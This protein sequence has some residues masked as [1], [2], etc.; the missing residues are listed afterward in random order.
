MRL[1]PGSSLSKKARIHGGGA[2]DQPQ[3]GGAKGG[4]RGKGKM[5]EMV[6]EERGLSSPKARRTRGIGRKLKG[7]GGEKAFRKTDKRVLMGE[8]RSGKP[9]TT[10]R[11]IYEK[12]KGFF[13]EIDQ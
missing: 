13:A 12:K 8:Q 3:G 2:A 9:T 4:G 1:T 11:F 10:R 6:G 7:M 5:G